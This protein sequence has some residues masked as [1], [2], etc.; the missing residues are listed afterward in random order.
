V[1]VLIVDD[2]FDL[3]RS[4]CRV[5]RDLGFL[6]VLEAADGQEAMRRLANFRPH[7]LIT[8]CQM[9]NMDGIRLTRALRGCGMTLP[10]VMISGVQDQ[11]IVKLA[12]NA[13]VN[14][15]L[16]KPVELFELRECLRH[17]LGHLPTAA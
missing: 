8:D 17:V 15:F 2:N 10:I 12:L 5:M 7:L 11:L 16:A 6:E 13:G 3:R 14:K 4:M 9:P 1:R